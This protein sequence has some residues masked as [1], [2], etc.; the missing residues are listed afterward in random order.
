[1]S[2]PD[3]GRGGASLSD[4]G[5]NRHLLEANNQS[6]QILAKVSATLTANGL[7]LKQGTASTLP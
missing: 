7:Y 5:I 3:W 4:E 1:M 6:A 2:L